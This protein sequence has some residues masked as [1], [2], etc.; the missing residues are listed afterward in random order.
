MQGT[1]PFATACFFFYFVSFL[2]VG[3]ATAH[4]RQVPRARVLSRLCVEANGGNLLLALGT[5]GGVSAGHRQLQE[6]EEE[7]AEAEEGEEAASAPACR[8]CSFPYLLVQALVHL[9][10]YIHKLSQD[11]YSVS[12][13][14]AE[15][16][17]YYC[18][19][20]VLCLFVP[21]LVY[22]AY[23][24]A[25]SIL[26]R[27]TPASDICTKLVNGLLLV[28]WQIKGHVEVLHFAAQRVCSCTSPTKKEMSRLR[29]L[30][31]ETFVLE[32]FEDFYAGFIQILLQLYLVVL[33]INSNETSK[34]RESLEEE[35]DRFALAQRT[36]CARV[37]QRN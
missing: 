35:G 17:L 24:V 29:S 2:K 26:D 11:A 1:P 36:A 9:C 30:K 32:F 12:T 28:P 4:F 5:Q 19:I 37:S 15:Q 23:L 25:D 27:S 22:A 8:G 13:Y 31:R 10:I 21:S 7:E 20:S 34:A 18:A 14:Y 6:R 33:F 3:F 16:Q